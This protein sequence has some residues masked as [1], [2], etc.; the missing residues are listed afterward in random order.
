V[1]VNETKEWQKKMKKIAAVLF[2]CLVLIVGV[3]ISRAAAAANDNNDAELRETTQVI[4]LLKSHY[5][6]HDKLDQKLLNDATVGGLL[7]TLGHGAQILTADEAKS[8]AAL[9]VEAAINTNEPLARAEV[10][11]PD[12]GYIRVGDVTENTVSAIDAELKAFADSKVEGYVLDLRFADGTNYAAAAEIAS[13]FVG[14]SQELFIVKSAE[15]IPQTFRAVE[16][17]HGIALD[18]GE[19]PLIVLVNNRT[20]GSAETLAAVLRAQD[21]VILVGNKTVGSAVAWE[22]IKLDAGRVLRVAT[23]KVELPKGPEIFPDGLTPDIPVKIDTKE[24][25]DTV[26]HAATN[27][28]LTVSLRPREHKI[29]SEA[30]LVKAFRG[31]AVSTNGVTGSGEDEGEIQKVHDVVL[32]RAV[33]ILKGIRVLLTSK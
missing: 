9:V 32:Q 12:I 14:P 4:D 19:A 16:T 1:Q 11:D 21:R 22:D 13:R 20:R 29:M 26:L 7:R 15:G 3:R 23:A 2:I 30:E 25:Q 31:E 6:D 10:I 28:T 33:D 8:N 18:L 17:P 27:M 24:E 5:V